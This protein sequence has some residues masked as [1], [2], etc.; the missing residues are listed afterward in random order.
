MTNG[1]P[2]KIQPLKRNTLNVLISYPYTLSVPVRMMNYKNGIILPPLSSGIYSLRSN[3][4][5]D[6]HMHSKV[7]IVPN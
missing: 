2:V 1:K 3:L 6:E 7:N 5:S 4:Q